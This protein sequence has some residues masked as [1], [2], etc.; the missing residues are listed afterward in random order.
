MEIVKFFEKLMS[1]PKVP[2]YKASEL[3]ANGYNSEILA[4]NIERVNREVWG[5]ICS[6]EYIFTKEKILTQLKNCPEH[7]F[8]AFA[9]KK[10]VA[11]LHLIYMRHEDFNSTKSWIEKTAHGTLSTHDPAGKIGF[12][13]DLSVTKDAPRGTAQRLLL[14]SILIDVIGIGMYEG[15]LG[16]RIPSFHK[17]SDKMSVEEYVFGKR[18]TGRA[19]DPELEFY[20]KSGFEIAEIIPDYMDDPESLNYGVLI[21]WKNPFYWLTRTLPF[22]KPLIRQIGYKY[23]LKSRD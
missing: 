13:V 3:L 20:R 10:M 9:G 12:G 21:R 18:K 1:K 14:G 5:N 23:I 4:E 19:W 11:T 16:S 15:F 8:C 2:I 7:I 17:Y 22:L 6:E